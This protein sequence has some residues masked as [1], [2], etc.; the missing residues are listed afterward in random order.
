M[1]EIII[2]LTGKQIKELAKLVESDEQEISI[3]VDK[4]TSGDFYAWYTDNPEE[5]AF[6][7][8]G[9]FDLNFKNKHVISIEKVIKIINENSNIY[10]ADKYSFDFFEDAFVYVDAKKIISI[11]KNKEAE[12]EAGTIKD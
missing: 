4:E 12:S 5:G 9:E 6:D 1:T 8:E 7:I 3:G 2:T 11:L 10:S